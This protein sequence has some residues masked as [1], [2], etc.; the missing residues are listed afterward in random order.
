MGVD[1]RVHACVGRCVGLHVGTCTDMRVGVCL[2]IWLTLCVHMRAGH[3]LLAAAQSRALAHG[4]TNFLA[5]HT[6][7]RRDVHVNGK[8]GLHGLVYAQRL[9]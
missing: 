3:D 4:V 2:D 6:Y 1:M 9:A 8:R 7:L 5:V